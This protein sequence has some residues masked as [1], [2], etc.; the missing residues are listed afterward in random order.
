MEKDENEAVVNIK[1]AT[2]LE[3]AIKKAVALGPDI[4]KGIIFTRYGMSARVARAGLA[5]ARQALDPENEKFKGCEC[6]K[7]E[8]RFTLQ[9]APRGQTKTV[10]Q[11]ALAQQGWKAALAKCLPDK[12]NASKT[13]WHVVADKMPPIRYFVLNGDKVVVN[14][15]ESKEAAAE[16]IN[17]ANKTLT[18]KSSGRSYLHFLSKV[19]E[20]NPK[21]QKKKIQHQ[22]LPST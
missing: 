17:K 14:K 21:P 19:V 5:T 13:F 12:L 20:P 9:G 3:E 2:K 22:S 1:T 7:G 16:T 10:I 4:Y 18:T 15:V 8:L 11:Q 6:V